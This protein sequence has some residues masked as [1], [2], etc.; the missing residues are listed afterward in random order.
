M[1]TFAIALSLLLST[2]SAL[3]CMPPP[4]GTPSIHVQKRFLN[5]LINSDALEEAVLNLAGLS[6]RIESISETDRGY[7]VQL[8]NLCKVTLQLDFSDSSPGT[9]PEFM[10]YKVVS[11]ACP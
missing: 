9:C 10:P 11:T 5:K 1:K 6:G 8:T 7:E 4:P 3:A 2:S